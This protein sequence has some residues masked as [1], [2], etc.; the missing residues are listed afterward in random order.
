MK[1]ALFSLICALSAF[2][3]SAQN[4]AAIPDTI[5]GCRYF[6]YDYDANFPYTHGNKK[7]YTASSWPTRDKADMRYYARIPEGHVKCTLVYNP[8]VNRAINL[9][10]TI[11]N[12]STNR[13]VYEKNI[14][15]EKAI[16]GGE[17]SLELFPDMVF[18]SDV[19]YQIKLYPHDGKYNS[20]PSRIVH[21]L[22]NREADKPAV[23]VNEVFMA[24]S[25]HNNE[26]LSTEPYAPDDNTYDWIYGEFLYPEEYVLPARYLM[27]LGGSGYY[28]GIQSTDGRG[29]VSA[30]FSAWDNGDTDVNPNLPDY[31]RSGAVD[32]NPDGGVKINRFGNEGTGVQSMMYPAR[33]LPGHWVQWLMNARPE[34]VE[35]ELPDNDGNLQTVKYANTILTAWYKMAD[36]PEWYYISTLRQS[37]TT[38]L[39]GRNGEYSFIECYGELGGD[40]LCRGYM[41]N[42]FFRSAGSG[43]WY[44]RNYMSGGHYDYNDGQRPC[45]YDYGH[46]ATSLYE[47]CFYI[48]HGGFGMVNDSS[49]YVAFPSSYECVDTIDLDSKQERINEAFR[50]ANYNQTINDI[51]YA[52]DAEVKDY[53]KELV[54]LVGKV[55]GYGQEHSADIIAAYNNG[56]PTDMGA[57]K[58]ALKQTALKYNKIR[59]ANV[60][61]KAHIGAQRAY[62]FD[63]TEGYGLLYVDSSSGTPIIKTADLDREDPRANWMIVR[64][65]KYG[66]LCIRNLATGLYINTATENMLSAEPQHIAAFARSGRGFYLGNTSTECVVAAADGTTSVGR[67][68]TTGGQYLLHDNL[69]MTPAT[70]LVQQVVEACDAPGKFEEYKTMVPDILATPEGVLGY[71][72]NP[73]ELEQLRTLYDDGNITDDKAAELIALIDGAQK[74]TAD[75]KQIGAF[76]ILFPEP[77]SETMST[78]TIGDDNSLSNKSITGKADQI[79]L[80]IPKQG[81]YEL[82]SQGRAINYLTDRGGVTVSTK[83]EGEGAPIFFTPQTAGQYSISD[84]QYGPVAINGSGTPIKTAIKGSEGNNWYIKPAETVKVTLNSGGVLSLYLDFDVQIPSG[85][86]VFTLAGFDNGVPALTTVTG[87]IPAHTPV[88]LKG[89]NYASLHFPII[90]AQT[91]SE[92]EGLMKGTL[93]KKTGM[94]SKTF[95]TVA[96]KSGTPCIALS[97]T[98]SVTANQ[99]YIL[100]EDMEAL[101]LTESQYNL[102]F[103]NATAIKEVESQESGVKSN[104]TYDLQGRPATEATKGIVIEKGKKVKK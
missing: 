25:A 24:P 59:Y 17:L 47:N 81:G 45:R 41:K 90:N 40:L 26:W 85:V 1:K 66:T 73:A 43:I 61:N 35:L 8:R 18:S 2:C 69:S 34:T 80:G 60:T 21:L 79:W 38:H 93:Q 54:D 63:N 28:S 39:F 84:V 15:V 68:S 6:S 30:L 103:D 98:N 102:D 95:Y 51:D 97:L 52:T 94:K 16:A 71:W 33:W 91:F 76:T 12:M 9:D 20:A 55:G 36:D 58:Q 10:V 62:V 96:V 70:E 99:C 27:C 57:L 65:D 4:Y 83:P 7:G 101:G 67:F 46:G 23:A 77:N 104:A 53:A 29:T 44:N 31:L 56:N 86:E 3:A 87:T 37:G 92:E 19:W 88:I 89:D 13:V 42:R 50:N 11:T 5:W 100:K 48:E 14:T 32:H 22:F 78:L 74:I 64:S 82:S 72:T 75:T 49:R